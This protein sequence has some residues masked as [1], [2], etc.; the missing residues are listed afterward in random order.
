MLRSEKRGV[1]VIEAFHQR[2]GCVLPVLGN[3]RGI[4]ERKVSKEPAEIAVRKVG[5]Q[6]DM[7]RAHSTVLGR[8]TP[9]VAS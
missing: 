6:T 2:L 3:L 9:P 7:S 8:Y 5:L 1:R 4:I